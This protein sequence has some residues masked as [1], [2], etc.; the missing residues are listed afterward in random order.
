METQSSQP[1]KGSDKDDTGTRS[2]STGTTS[3]QFDV[4][5]LDE[6]VLLAGSSASFAKKFECLTYKTLS[7]MAE[8]Q[9]VNSLHG[10][11][12]YG[13]TRSNELEQMTKGVVSSCGKRGSL[14]AQ[15][16]KTNSQKRTTDFVTQR[17]TEVTDAPGFDEP[18]SKKIL[19]YSVDAIAKSSLQR[20]TNDVESLNPELCNF[21]PNFE[22]Q[23]ENQSIKVKTFKV[24]H[25]PQSRCVNVNEIWTDMK[26]LRSIVSEPENINT[27]I[28]REET[29]LDSKNSEN[30]SCSISSVLLECD[31][32]SD[33]TVVIEL[34]ASDYEGFTI[35]ESPKFEKQEKL[36]HKISEREFC[37]EAAS[38][39]MEAKRENTIDH[40]LP[41]QSE[42]EKVQSEN[43]KDLNMIESTV[44]KKPT[45]KLITP[46]TP[47]IEHSEASPSNGLE[48]TLHTHIAFLTDSLVQRL[49]SPISAT[50]GVMTRDLLG[51]DYSNSDYFSSEKVRL[52][53]KK[54]SGGRVKCNE[55]GVTTTYRAFY[56]HAKKH[57]HV[58]PFKCGYCSYRSIEKSKIRVHNT[59][60]HPSRPC[61]ILK[62]SPETAGV[63]TEGPQQTS[64]KMSQPSEERPPPRANKIDGATF[65]TFPDAAGSLKDSNSTNISH[66]ILPSNGNSS[67]APVAVTKKTANKIGDRHSPPTTSS[68]PSSVAA[69]P[70]TFHCPICYK[71]LQIHTPSI[72][73]HLYSHYGYKPY[74]CG[75]CNFT[76]IGQNE[77]SGKLFLFSFFV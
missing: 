29:S 24:K 63:T 20:E 38:V 35:K 52:M 47:R 57:F 39:Y 75:Y 15:D 44:T 4:D 46:E 28:N 65:I 67:E 69:G 56:K 12:E 13:Q 74:K 21:K 19:N 77:V 23:P 61:I 11:Q 25:A 50:P 54:K 17:E 5:C 40:S 32:C 31:D 64:A 73:R 45:S 22:L 71:Q 33:K 55:C 58:K 60:C 37:T 7:V 70:S 43:E 14:I 16:M 62:L 49:S 41:V 6:K 53:M 3:V 72:R 48:N 68:V 9:V 8:D 26:K 30:S 66:R 42:N 2:L 10:Q 59:F 34:C 18:S 76:A 36:E 51:L 27:I 1:G